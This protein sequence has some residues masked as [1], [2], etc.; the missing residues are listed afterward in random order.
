M[1]VSPNTQY[2]G[3]LSV[4]DVSRRN[5]FKCITRDMEVKRNG[6]CAVPVMNA[7]VFARETVFNIQSSE[8]DAGVITCEGRLSASSRVYDQCTLGKFVQSTRPLSHFLE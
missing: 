4:T 7:R 3:I 1:T 6:S 5:S 8:S 2:K